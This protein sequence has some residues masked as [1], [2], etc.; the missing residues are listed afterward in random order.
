M[1]Y[2]YY[3]KIFIDRI[4]ISSLIMIIVFHEDKNQQIQRYIGK[5][6]FYGKR[7]NTRA[8]SMRLLTRDLLAHRPATCDL[9]VL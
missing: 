5:N 4:K 1:F 7:W 8:M 9:I 2:I 3:G 6:V